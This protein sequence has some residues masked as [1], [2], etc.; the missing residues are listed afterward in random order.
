MKERLRVIRFVIYGNN[1]PSLY[2]Q[3]EALDPTIKH[4][5]EIKPYKSKRSLEQN[6]WVRGYA[7][8]LGQHLGY[9]A[10]EMYEL[11]MY[12]FNPL[13]IV[14]KETGEQIRMAGHF[15]S[16]KTDV[17]ADVQDQIQRWGGNLGFYW[18]E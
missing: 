18:N 9:E 3:I 4:V 11:L 1:K 6:R 15:S 16:L 2:K 8:D 10:D 7:K 17:A 13:F 5:A 14:D 12:K